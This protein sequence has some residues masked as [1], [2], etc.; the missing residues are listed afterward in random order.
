MTRSRIAVGI[1]TANRPTILAE[2]L[3]ELSNQ[4]RLPDCVFVCP[5]A[6]KDFDLAQ[7][8]DLPYPVLVVKGAKGSSSQRNAIIDSALQFDVLLFLD[9][10]FF[11]S[12]TYLAEL[13][14]CFTSH[15]TVVIAHGHVI[16]DGARGPGLDETAARNALSLFRQSIRSNQPLEDEYSAY[17]CNMAVRLRPVYNHSIRF[18]ENLPLYGWLEDLDFSRQLSPYGRIVKNWRTTGVHLGAKSGRGGSGVS[19]GYSQIAN[20]IYLWRKGTAPLDRT[21]LILLRNTVAN[22]AKTPM[23]EPWIDRRGRARGNGLAFLDL[24]RGRLNPRRIL[25]SL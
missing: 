22:L 5:A 23:P 11:P 18:D 10:D 8:A 12:C 1:A 7:G 2:V 6:E 16:A 24:I 19:Y 17:G 15:P 4:T 14:L 13:D 25:E 21:L 20:P 3:R 9:D